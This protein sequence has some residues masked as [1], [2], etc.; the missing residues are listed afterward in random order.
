MKYNLRQDENESMRVIIDCD[1]GTAFRAP[2]SMTAWRW[3]WRLPPR[4][5]PW[6]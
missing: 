3:R 1:P 2:I 6:K 4:K 5:S